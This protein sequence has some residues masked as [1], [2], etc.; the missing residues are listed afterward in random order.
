MER[1]AAEEATQAPQAIN[2]QP[3]IA[4]NA[5]PEGFIKGM[6]V[7]AV[8]EE[9]LVDKPPTGKKQRMRLH[10][11]RVCLHFQAPFPTFAGLRRSTSWKRP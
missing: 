7:V 5:L 4:T 9:E 8:V 2:A 11:R 10:Q 3:R 1:P 6:Q